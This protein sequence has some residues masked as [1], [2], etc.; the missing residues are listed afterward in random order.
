MASKIS[1]FI[2][3]RLKIELEALAESKIEQ[4]LSNLYDKDPELH[5]AALIAGQQFVKHVLPLA[6]KTKTPI[7]NAVLEAM[8]DAIAASAADYGIDL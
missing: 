2:L 1:E 3:N 6:D 7:D 5:R 8:G 4:L